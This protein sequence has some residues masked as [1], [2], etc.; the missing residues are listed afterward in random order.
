MMKKY[1]M[2]TSKW[3]AYSDLAWVESTTRP[4]EYVEET[5]LFSKVIKEHSKIEARTLLHLGCGAGI[6]DYTFKRHFKVAGVDISEDMLEIA[7]KL[8]PEVTYLYGDMRTI[9][10][11]ECFDAVAI[12]DSIGYMTT[13]E[14]LRSAIITAYKHL[15]PGGV[16]LIVANIKED[17]KENNF[18]YTDSK[19][20]VEITIFENN[21]VPDPRG[22]TYEA[23]LI[24]LIRR[25]GKLEIYTDRHIIGLFKLETWLELLKGGGFEVKQMKLEH[26]YDRF[27]LGKSEYPLLMFVCSKPL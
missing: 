16:L 14:D 26:S 27:I 3:R 1:G 18:V 17:F 12:P 23:T 2:K 20:N 6:N 13:P 24:Y 10:L 7:R 22:T 11:R 19:E 25:K 21:Y 8:N 9:R 5:E 4:E 15:K